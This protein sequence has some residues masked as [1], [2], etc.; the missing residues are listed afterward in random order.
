[1]SSKSEN[2][3]PKAEQEDQQKP[4]KQPAQNPP[5]EKRTRSKRKKNAESSEEF[6]LP[7]EIPLSDSPEV[8]FFH[9]IEQETTKVI[10]QVP[11]ALYASNNIS[12]E[13]TT[14]V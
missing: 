12:Q 3:Q 10:L 7:S 6:A 5:P 1:M 2:G 4:L 11:L 9:S 8:M 13:N 14:R